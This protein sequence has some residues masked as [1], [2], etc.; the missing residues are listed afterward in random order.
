M[1]RGRE[2]AREMRK[3]AQLVLVLEN[4]GQTEAI[5]PL[6]HAV[7]RLGSKVIGPHV[8]VLCL[9]SVLSVHSV[10]FGER[11]DGVGRKQDRARHLLFVWT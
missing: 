1:L 7:L 4:G 2:L 6:D 3:L 9:E 5:H 10:I 11:R 8:G